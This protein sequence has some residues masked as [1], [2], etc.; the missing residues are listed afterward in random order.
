M[1][2]KHKHILIINYVSKNTETYLYN[3]GSTKNVEIRISQN[4]FSISA[5]LTKLYDKSEMVSGNSYLFP[6]AIKKA[7]LL[8]LLKYSKCIDIKSITVRIDDIKETIPITNDNKL[9]FSLVDSSLVRSLPSSF[10][11]KD[12]VQYVLNTT[13]SKYDKRTASLFA[14]IYSKSKIFETERFI[15]LWTAFN[16]MYSWLS[17]YIAKA[18][19]V[20]RYRKEYK[21]IIGIQKY[22]EIGS[23]TIKDND[24][25]NI[26]HKVI[27]ILTDNSVHATKQDNF[28]IIQNKINDVLKKQDGSQYNLSAY[29]YLLTQLTYY[30][31]CKIVHGSKPIILFTFSD[32]TEVHCLKIL[33]RLLEE[34][35]ENNL[36][37]WFSNDYI[38]RILIPKANT[39]T[40]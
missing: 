18:N 7:M 16:G 24:K 29:G 13:K 14:F 31:R 8:Y 4:G 36:H 21:Q 12:I 2:D 19:N 33:N 17:E 34:F 23:E 35:I 9:V 28:S 40:L 5:E 25:S 10:Y 32:E 3:F 1:M 38:N 30:F 26:A 39:I 11:S 22:F 6:D 20:D 27:S 37:L 15:Y